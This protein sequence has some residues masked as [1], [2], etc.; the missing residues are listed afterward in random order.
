MQA[1]C[2]QFRR[3]VQP[4]C[5]VRSHAHGS[6][7][8]RLEAAADKGGANNVRTA[9]EWQVRRQADACVTPHATTIRL[10]ATML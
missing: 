4:R 8:V 5:A 1:L 6:A 9:R 10:L 7:A 3:A 2:A